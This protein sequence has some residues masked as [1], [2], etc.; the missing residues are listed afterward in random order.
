M[1][2]LAQPVSLPHGAVGLTIDHNISATG[3]GAALKN[4]STLPSNPELLP[5]GTTDQ[6]TVPTVQQIFANDTNPADHMQ[7]IRDDLVSAIG[8]RENFDALNPFTPGMHQNILAIHG[9]AYVQERVAAI[10]RLHP[11]IPTQNPALGRALKMFTVGEDFYFQSV[12][13]IHIAVWARSYDEEDQ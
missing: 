3:W 4:V 2:V 1:F 8:T 6:L 13:F 10:L 12:D 9:Y 7:A 5:T 11:Y